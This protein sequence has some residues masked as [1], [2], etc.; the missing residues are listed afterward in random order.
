MDAAHQLAPTFELRFMSLTNG[1][2]GFAFPCDAGGH[3][4]LD[5][6]TE[7]G[8]ISYFGARALVG[9]EYSFTFVQPAAAH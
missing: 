1:G 2:R 5:S 8:R 6:L 3:V 9:R 4:D 7:R